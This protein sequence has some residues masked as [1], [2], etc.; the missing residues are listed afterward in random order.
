MEDADRREGKETKKGVSK[1]EEGKKRRA[2]RPE[3]VH[4]PSRT[5]TTESTKEAQ[6]LQGARMGKKKRAGPC[7]GGSTGRSRFEMHH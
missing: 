7:S 6:S 1:H 4:S 5:P 2:N 3:V